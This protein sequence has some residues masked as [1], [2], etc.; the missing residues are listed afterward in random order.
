L[1]VAIARTFLTKVGA[2]FVKKKF[3][4][5]GIERVLNQSK[6]ESLLSWRP[7]AAAL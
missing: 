1:T 6:P 7:G 4:N 2:G 5:K 3:Y